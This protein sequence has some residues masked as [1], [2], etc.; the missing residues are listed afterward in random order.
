ML[1]FNLLRIRWGQPQFNK[2]FQRFSLWLFQPRAL[3]IVNVVDALKL[4]SQNNKIK[5]LAEYSS[6]AGRKSVTLPNP[7]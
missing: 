7:S 2:T 6:H 4:I 1:N 5:P 3:D